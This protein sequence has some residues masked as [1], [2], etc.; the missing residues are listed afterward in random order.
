MDLFHSP[1][2]RSSLILHLRIA[3]TKP[4]QTNRFDSCT[5]TGLL[6]RYL[7]TCDS[8]VEKV[9]RFIMSR[10]LMSSHLKKKKM[11]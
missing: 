6:L 5:D 3:H 11:R 1:S 8:F 10:H 9:S 2:M 4:Q 7:L